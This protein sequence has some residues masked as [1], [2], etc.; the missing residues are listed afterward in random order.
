VPP[1]HNRIAALIGQLELFLHDDAQRLPT[2]V[3]AALAHVQFE[4]IHP[5]LDGNGRLGRLLVTF[6][7]CAAG[8][9]KDPLLYLSLYLKH[10][11][12][13]YYD[14]LQ[15]VRTEGEWEP[16]LDF[17]LTG[18]YET[19]TGAARIATATLQLFREDRARIEGAGQAVA[20]A[21]RVH[22][23]FQRHPIS[24]VSRAAGPLDLTFPT[25]GK[26]VDR[27]LALG[28][29]REMTGR[30]RDRV[31]ACGRYLDLMSEG[32]EPLPR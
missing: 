20:N 25:V 31:F 16:W 1:P 9:M 5:F 6:L 13:R 30:R 8:M 29:L 10:H 18:V 26:A 17:F 24:T 12:E 14:L 7:L 21:L 22:D 32:T 4:T 2:I 27:L 28:I 11:R 23:H 19:A 3:K 15:R